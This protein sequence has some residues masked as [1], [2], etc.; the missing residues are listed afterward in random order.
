MHDRVLP[1]DG[2]LEPRTHRHQAR[3][4]GG[5]KTHAEVLC[6]REHE[7]LP[8]KRDVDRHGARLP[9]LGAR[10]HARI[11]GDLQRHPE[12]HRERRD[13][14]DGHGDHLSRLASRFHTH[15]AHGGLEGH[16][17]HRLDHGDASGLQQS[18]HRADR[19]AARHGSESAL[20]HDNDRDIG[21]RIRWREREY[22]AQPRISA[23]LV[24][25]ETSQTMKLARGVG[26]AFFD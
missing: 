5:L 15:E 24:K 23:G 26:E 7:E 14:L 21:S 12:M 19:V 18:G 25:H 9:P 13:I 2:Q 17:R 3:Y 10:L 8:A 20:L 6:A 1:I 11:D 4:V 16:R 22:R